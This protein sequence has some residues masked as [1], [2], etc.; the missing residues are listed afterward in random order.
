MLWEIA[1]TPHRLLGSV[2]TLSA[3]T[4]FP[5]WV[6]A[7][8]EGIDRFVFESGG[9]GS[10]HEIGVDRTR[11]H[12]KLPEVSE[13]YQSAKTLLASIGSYDP[14]DDLLPWRAAFHVVDRFLPVLGV[15]PIYGVDYR[16][17]E[18]AESDRLKIDFLESSTRSSELIDSSCKNSVG[19]LSFLEQTVENIASGESRIELRRIIRAWLASDLVDF[20]AIRDEH[21]IKFSYL[22]YPIITQRNREWG[23]VAKRLCADKSPT[24]FIVGCLHTIG[25]G[26]FIEHLAANGLR[27]KFIA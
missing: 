12:L 7:S 2:H 14:F 22:F 6:K 26:S 21:L 25:S 3:E 11:A 20:N 8:Y 16:L 9:K 13:V 15:S 1:D 19:G 27:L 24:L 18:I 10:P 17:R 4:M 23:P 5:N